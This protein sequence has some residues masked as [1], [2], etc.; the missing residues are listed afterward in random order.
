MEK[1]GQEAPSGR[2]LFMLR[3]MGLLAPPASAG[4]IAADPRHP[5]ADRARDRAARARLRRSSKLIALPF[6]GIGTG[7]AV[8]FGFLL[9]VVVLGVLVLLGQDA[10]QAKATARR[11]PPAAAPSS[12][13]RRRRAGAGSSRASG[14]SG[15]SSVKIATI[16]R[17]TSSRRSGSPQCGLQHLEGAL[18]VARRPRP[19][20]PGRRSSS[21]ASRARAA[22]PSARKS[23]VSGLEQLERLVGVA[24]ARAAAGPAPRRATGVA[25]GRARARG[26]ATASSP[27]RGQLVGLGRHERVEEALHLARAAARR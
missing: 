4:I 23:P 1:L 25:A 13:Q 9:V 21:P 17:R 6:G 26:A 7:S 8:F 3:L 20:R 10:R 16:T 14:W 11:A 2:Q 5:A 18:V 12:V 15:P 27:P 19:R 24:A 22:R